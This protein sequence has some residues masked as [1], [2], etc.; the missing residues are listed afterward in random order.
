MKFVFLMFKESLFTL[1]HSCTLHNSSLIFLKRFDMLLSDKNKFM[2]SANI[3]EFSFFDALH[4]S[5]IYIINRSGPSIEPCR[6]P[7]ETSFRSIL[8]LSNTIYCLR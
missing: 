3:I 8:D 4:R 6:T 2:S 1:N 5:L 7:Q